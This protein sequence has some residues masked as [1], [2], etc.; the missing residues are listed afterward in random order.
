MND[1]LTMYVGAA[2]QH[3]VRMSFAPEEESLN[4]DTQVTAFW[5]HLIGLKGMVTDN[6]GVVVFG[7]VRTIIGIDSMKCTG[8]I[9]DVHR[10]C[11]HLRT[12]GVKTSELVEFSSC[13]KGMALNFV[14]DKVG[15]VVF[16]VDRKKKVLEKRAQVRG[17]EKW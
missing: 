12:Q 17:P 15:V 5:S 13:L 7:D 10:L 14:T 11:S 3:V 9:A 6:M 1:L 4:F 2:S 16:G 8:T